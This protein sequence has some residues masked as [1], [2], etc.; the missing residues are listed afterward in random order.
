MCEGN[1]RRGKRRAG[2][3]PCR[4]GL[5][6]LDFIQGAIRISGRVLGN[7]DSWKDTGQDS[8]SVRAFL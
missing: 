8:D 1:G 7:K 3:K 6:N 4:D 2:L 5:R